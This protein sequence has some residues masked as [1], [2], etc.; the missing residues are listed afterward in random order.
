MD[1]Y[2]DDTASYCS[3]Y[4]SELEDGPSASEGDA[5]GGGSY[6]MDTRT[7]NDILAHYTQPK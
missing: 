5:Y 3:D 4:C 2:T 6:C 1:T 7:Y